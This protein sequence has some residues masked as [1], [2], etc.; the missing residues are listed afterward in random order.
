M[1]FHN[2]QPRSEILRAHQGWQVGRISE[3]LHSE[4]RQ[5][6]LWS[7]RQHGR[8]FFF[9]SKQAVTYFPDMLVR[10][11]QS[12]VPGIAAKVNLCMCV[13]PC[14]IRMRLKADKR[15]KSME[16]REEEYQRARERIFAHD[17]RGSFCRRELV[18][19]GHPLHKSLCRF[20]FTNKFTRFF[21]FF[22]L[23]I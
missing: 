3:T 16:E 9:R 18:G 22:L 6:Q 4:T 1:N 5:L 2:Q 12:G 20:L 23:Q 11:G 15:S 8:W 7:W 19:G 10:L 21:F 13:C 17:V 14:Q